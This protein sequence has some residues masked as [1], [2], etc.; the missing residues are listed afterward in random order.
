MISW[1]DRLSQLIVRY[2]GVNLTPRDTIEF[3]GSGVSVADDSSNERTQVTIAGF[4]APTGSGLL[5]VTSGV[6]D[7][8][9]KPLATGM[10]TFLGSGASAD[11]IA[12]MTNET[13]TGALV[14]HN[15]PTLTTPK[16]NNPGGTFQYSLVVSAITAGRSITLPLLVGND[17]FV[18]Q[19]HIQTLT[20]KTMS[21]ASNT[22]SN[23][24]GSAVAASSSSNAGT[25][26]AADKTK[27]DGIQSQGTSTAIAALSIDW[28]LGGVYTKT[29]SAGANTFTFANATDG[30]QIIV[31]LTGAVSTV[32]WPTV[33]W[34]GGVA[35]TQTSAGTDV[36]TF[37]KAGTTIY[38]TAAQ[39]MA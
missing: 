19:D 18:F 23:I 25:M 10:A 13:G 17:V 32:T 5:T 31:I 37:V 30:Q 6:L 24:P 4:A 29:L 11:L 28:S 21:G 8:A 3:L 12:A 22:F 9:S 1:L 7:A 39:A 15:T 35:P 33:K 20:N 36:Y 16:I 26:S 27:L 2:A 34:P 14:F 38:G